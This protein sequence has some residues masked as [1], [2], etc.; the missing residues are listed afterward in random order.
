MT[1]S[2]AARTGLN[3]DESSLVVLAAALLR[4]A[5]ELERELPD[6]AETHRHVLV[7]AAPFEQLLRHPDDRRGGRAKAKVATVELGHLP[8]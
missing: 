5:H 3:Y 7:Q 6:C 2:A 8:Q 1:P 4:L